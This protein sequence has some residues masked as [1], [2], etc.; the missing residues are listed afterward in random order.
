MSIVR[1]AFTSFLLTSLTACSLDHGAPSSALRY[2][3]DAQYVTLWGCNIRLPYGF[4][5]TRIQS[6][7]VREFT[8]LGTER[9]TYE[10]IS[11]GL[12]TRQFPPP[13]GP[14]SELFQSARL[15]RQGD[16]YI[17]QAKTRVG[18]QPVFTYHI[19]ISDGVSQLGAT[20]VTRMG[21]EEFIGQ[22]P[23]LQ[24]HALEPIWSYRKD[25]PEDEGS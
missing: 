19:S 4:M 17:L 10:S 14:F 7:G 21:I 15:W 24:R 23:E 13:K 2:K 22:C 1:G 12:E 9:T 11:T 5:E 25:S 8:R 18:Q 16:L 3:G 6:S 20:T